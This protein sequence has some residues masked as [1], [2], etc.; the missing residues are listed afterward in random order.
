MRHEKELGALSSVYLNNER[1][2]YYGTATHDFFLSNGLDVL[3]SMQS[4]FEALLR[5]WSDHYRYNL[6]AELVNFNFHCADLVLLLD[7]VG[8]C[9]H[10]SFTVMSE[11]M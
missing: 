9:R 10:R 2:A 11:L 1:L 6:I 7:C 5:T 8:K 4:V 3:Q